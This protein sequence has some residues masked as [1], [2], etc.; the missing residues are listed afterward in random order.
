MWYLKINQP[1][2]SAISLEMKISTNN[3]NTPNYSL[4]KLIA[5]T[6][7]LSV[8]FIK[9]TS[10]NILAYFCN[11][12]HEE[13]YQTQNLNYSCVVSKWIMST[14]WD[15]ESRVSFA[16]KENICECCWKSWQPSICS[17]SFVRETW[18]WETVANLSR[19]ANATFVTMSVVSGRSSD[20]K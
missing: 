10:P 15:T 9:C 18:E 1:I 13:R 2:E 5:L 17:L 19:K 14:G 11:L 12:T 4:W 7:S 20:Y 8:K 16:A 6:D 3:R